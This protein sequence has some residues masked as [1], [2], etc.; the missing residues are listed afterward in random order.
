MCAR[1]GEWP[2]VQHNEAFGVSGH[3]QDATAIN[4]HN[5]GW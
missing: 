3:S 1:K 5:V 4:G 2:L